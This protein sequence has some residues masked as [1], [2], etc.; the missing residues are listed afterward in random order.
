MGMSETVG[1][2]G[3]PRSGLL[4][5]SGARLFQSLVV[6]GKMTVCEHLYS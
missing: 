1:I 4:H 2:L 6:L 5:R 3:D